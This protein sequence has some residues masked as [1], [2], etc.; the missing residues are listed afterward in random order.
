MNAR[1]STIPIEITAP[2][3]LRQFA[4]GRRHGDCRQLRSGCLLEHPHQAQE[5]GERGKDEAVSI[6]GNGALVTMV[7]V[8]LAGSISMF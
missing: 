6:S 1:I 2:V 5:N 3:K 7:I 8:T 4:L